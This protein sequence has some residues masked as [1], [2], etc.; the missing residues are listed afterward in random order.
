MKAL[1][2]GLFV[3]GMLALALA[4]A[5]HATL[6]PSCPVEESCIVEYYHGAWHVL[7]TGE[8]FSPATVRRLTTQELTDAVCGPY[9]RLVILPD[10]RYVCEPG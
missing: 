2:F 10:E 5:V 6:T 1:S 9:S 7:P 4:L 8:Y 3:V